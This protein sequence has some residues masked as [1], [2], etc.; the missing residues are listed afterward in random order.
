MQ[1][2]GEEY[3]NQMGEEYVNQ[4]GRICESQGKNM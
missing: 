1:I 4:M 2:K 3:V